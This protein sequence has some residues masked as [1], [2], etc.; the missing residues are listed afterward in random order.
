MT[1]IFFCP[2]ILRDYDRNLFYMDELIEKGYN[3][4]FLD[5]TEYFNN[6]STATDKFLASRTVRCSTA[7]DFTAFKAT[8]PKE[9]VL[10]LVFD[11]QLKKV[12]PAFDLLV[13]K[14]DKILSY[15]TKRVFDTVV[16]KS[17][18]NSYF[19][20]AIVKAEEFLPLHLFK[21]WY[22]KHHS[23][24]IPDYFLCSTKYL[25]PVKTYLTVKSQNRFNVHADDINKIIEL[26]TKSQNPKKIGVFL[27]QGLPFLNRTHPKLYTKP[28]PPGYLEEYY[29]KLSDKLE[30]HKLELGLDE[31]VVALHPDAVKFES[32]LQGK[33]KNHKT[34]L[35]ETAKLIKDA[36]VV[37]GHCSAALSFA[38]YLEKP[39]VIFT[40]RYIRD[41]DKNIRAA[42]YFF[43]EN[44]GMHEVN[45]DENIVLSWKNITID[46]TKYRDYKTK[47]LKD[48]NIQENSYYYA[49]RHI[50]NDL[51]R[52]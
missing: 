45:L 25:M 44:V 22:R 48:N 17:S 1:V 46:K 23:K 27:D 14:Q 13:R 10:F 26:P 30:Q 32:E 9:P 11:L 35:G 40:D 33:F 37:F 4:I 34:V 39:V 31:I 21:F 36:S 3:P 43:I 42:T 20:K 16:E 5:A 18:L 8:L 38:I 52:E 7:K 6:K 49:I 51:E 47:Y 28:L 15:F 19:R 24:Y 12:A 41:Y 29:I 50:K 2:N